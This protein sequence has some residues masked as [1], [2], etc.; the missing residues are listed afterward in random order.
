MS[1]GEAGMSLGH[2]PTVGIVATILVVAIAISVAV[3][4]RTD[5]VLT[6]MN[7]LLV[8][9]VPMQ[10]VIGLVWHCKQPAPIA[11]LPQPVRGLAFLVLTV[12]VGMLVAM[13]AQH[14][15]GGGLTPP[16]PFV[17]MFVIFS[18]I[19]TIW[20]IVPMQ[21]WPFTAVLGKLPVAMGFALLL[22]AYALAWILFNASFDFGFLHQAPFYSETLDPHGRFTAWNPLTFGICSVATILSLVL[23]DF[24]PV[25]I[26]ARTVPAFGRQPLFG[27]ASGALIALIV[28]T[29]WQ[30]CVVQLEMDVVQLLVRAVSMIFG[31]FIVLVMFEGAPFIRLPQPRRGLVL[32]SVAAIL[33]VSMYM[34]YRYFA[35]NHLALP[36]GVP[37]YTLELWLATSML[38]MTFPFMVLYASFFNY[39]PLRQ[40]SN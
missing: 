38:A 18:V 23:L 20:L 37:G 22:A 27:L 17:N 2:Q 14:T 32:I 12:G 33:A 16:T 28:T 40:T 7:L 36:G 9:M 30:I 34:L 29:I 21:C 31:I 8:S 13:V 39:W 25:S 5:L 10:M 24:W 15:V 4:L 3:A 35:V 6:W 19:V 26:L 11:R 1:K